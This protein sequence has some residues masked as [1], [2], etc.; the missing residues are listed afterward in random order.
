MRTVDA[1]ATGIVSFAQAVAIGKTAASF[2]VRIPQ[3]QG[4]IRVGGAA[5]ISYALVTRYVNIPITLGS[6][7]IG[8]IFR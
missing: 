4:A 7:I 6:L 5:M 1:A 3:D 2:T 8:R